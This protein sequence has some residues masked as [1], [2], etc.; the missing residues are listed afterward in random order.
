L[1]LNFGDV[2][3]LQALWTLY[4]FK[5]YSV[6][7]YKGFETIAR[8]GGEMTEY[9]FTILLL[10]KTKTLAVVKPFYRSVYHLLSFS[11]YFLLVFYPRNFAD[12]FTV[13]ALVE[14][15]KQLNVLGKKELPW[16]GKWC[17]T[18]VYY[19]HGERPCGFLFA[20]GR[21]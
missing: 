11:S 8:D 14:E 4:H 7:F 3:R 16:G 2:G 15:C 18:W 1:S 19:N 13:T 10:K 9:I 21:P 17:Y 12:F 20:E 5:R 6:A